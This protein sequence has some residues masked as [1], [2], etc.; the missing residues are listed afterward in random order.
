[1]RVYVINAGAGGKPG[2][3]HIHGG[4]FFKGE[5]KNELHTLQDTATAVHCVIVTVD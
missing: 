1:V 2:V 5:A 3:L 4:G